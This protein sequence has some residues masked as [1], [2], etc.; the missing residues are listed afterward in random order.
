GAGEA[1]H[2]DVVAVADQ[3]GGIVGRHEPGMH[4]GV[5]DAGK[6]M[7]QAGLLRDRGWGGFSRKPRVNPY[8]RRSL[9]IDSRSAMLAGSARLERRLG[10]EQTIHTEAAA[11]SLSDIDRVIGFWREAG[12]KDLW[13]RKD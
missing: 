12:E 3:R 2:A 7:F 6:G 1:A 5:L 13:F 4:A 11:H 9:D 10:M 8:S